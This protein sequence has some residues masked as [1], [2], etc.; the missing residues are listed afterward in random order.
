MNDVVHQS[1][2]VEAFN[3]N[4]TIYIADQTISSL[5]FMNEVPDALVVFIVDITHTL[6]VERSYS[7]LMPE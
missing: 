5:H 6:V 7:L 4:P 1:M 3:L 2:M